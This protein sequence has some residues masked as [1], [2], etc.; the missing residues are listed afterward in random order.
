MWVR[1]GSEAAGG[2]TLLELSRLSP[3]AFPFNKAILLSLSPTRA[4]RYRV[5][6][7]EA[8]YP[9]HWHVDL[10]QNWHPGRI[11]PL[12]HLY[13]TALSRRW[14][15]DS[16]APLPL[17]VWVHAGVTHARD[18]TAT[19]WLDGA[20]VASKEVPLAEAVWRE[21]VLVGQSSES[22]APD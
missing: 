6:Q 11:R 18:G 22:E 17:Q 12:C 21:Q 4:L 10:E 5:W 16:P 8:E 13:E 2:S 9:W 1:L 7:E 3:A 14:F 15:L 20:A 19:L